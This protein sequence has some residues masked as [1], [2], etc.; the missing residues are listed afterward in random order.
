[1]SS[2]LPSE[3]NVPYEYPP[4]LIGTVAAPIR[5][6]TPTDLALGA[7]G[8]TIWLDS[9]TEIHYQE[10]RGQRVAGAF[11]RLERRT[12]DLDQTEGNP[13]SFDN[14][15]SREASFVF[16]HQEGGGWTKLTLDEEEGVIFLGRVSGVI[17]MFKYGA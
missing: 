17:D 2:E 6:A 1:V 4:L 8:T 10:S 13:F 12:Q 11:A 3:M 15:E 14:S 16:A 5:L 9:H 7:Y